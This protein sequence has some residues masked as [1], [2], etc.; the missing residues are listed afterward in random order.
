MVT[1]RE[2]SW[3]TVRFGGIPCKDV[4]H[5]PQLS[6]L[7]PLFEG[8]GGSGRL[9]V[10]NHNRRWMRKTLRIMWT[11]QCDFDHLRKSLSKCV[12]PVLYCFFLKEQFAARKNASCQLI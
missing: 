12:E 10:S 9:A 5:I 3:L 4:A 11:H 1:P 6:N 7:S 2:K 8:G